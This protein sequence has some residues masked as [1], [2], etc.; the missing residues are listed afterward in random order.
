MRN[1]LKLRERPGE[2]VPQEVYGWRPYALAFSASWASAMYGYDSAFIGGTLN[3]PSFQRT[4]GLADASKRAKADLSSNIVSTF[5]GGAFFGCAAGFFMAER[6]GRKATIMASAVIFTVGAILQMIGRLDLLYAGRVFTGWGVGASAMILP[7]YVSECSPALIRGRLVG[8]FEIMLQVALVF[9]FWVNYGVNKNIPATTSKQWHI[10]VAVQFI[11]AGLLVLTMIPMIES[12][13]W[14]MSKG[15]KQEAAKALSWVRHLPEDHPWIIHELSV[16]E[17]AIESEVAG[18]PRTWKQIGR[19]LFSAGV[20]GRIIISFM[21]MIFQN[22]TGINAINYYSPTIFTSI[23]FTG[24]SNGL[25]ATGI[26]GIVKMVATM[27]YAGF[28]V[29]KVGRRNLLLIGGAGAGI[30]MFYLAGYSQISG[31]FERTP[32]LD[33][34]AR[35]AVAMVYIYA[36]FYGLSWNGIPWLF[37]SEV[38]PTRV[39]TAGMAF[40]VCIQW[41]T[42]FVVVYSLPHMVI[43]IKHGTFLFFG[44]CTVLAIGFAWLFV[45]ETKGVQ[46]EDMDLL[47]GRDVSIVATKARQNYEDVRNARVVVAEEKGSVVYE[48]KV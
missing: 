43:G 3:L 18:S 34:G 48:E 19:E 33:S 47:F 11:P 32:P 21:M 16:V 12:P 29:D 44:A 30:S 1:I 37:C 8:V 15:R 14:L 20:R 17:N 9:G 40:C 7:I 45:P 5:Q 22:F 39:R 6:F 23:G 42:Q 38:L 28:L 27:L 26:F 10:P 35:A 4:F 31:S 36:L 25:L 24:T 46:L 2:E 41:L 13:R